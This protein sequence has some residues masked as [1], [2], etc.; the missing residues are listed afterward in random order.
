MNR[1][2]KRNRKKKSISGEQKDP[3]EIKKKNEEKIKAEKNAK[4]N[5]SKWIRIGRKEESQEKM[6]QNEGLT[7]EEKSGVKKPDKK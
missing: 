5:K 6:A 1:I 4:E 2:L 7:A 3:R